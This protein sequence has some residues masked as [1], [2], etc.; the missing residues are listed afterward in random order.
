MSR[1]RATPGL[2]RGSRL[3]PATG[4]LDPVEQRALERR[5]GQYDRHSDL[6]FHYRCVYIRGTRYD[7]AIGAHVEL[8]S[9]WA[10]ALR[11]LRCITPT[12]SGRRND[13]TTGLSVAQGA[14]L[15]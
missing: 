2:A 12:T 1:R 11:H 4:K 5:R 8:L 15:R 9:P 7:R 14:A 10:R 13:L 3:V 6:G